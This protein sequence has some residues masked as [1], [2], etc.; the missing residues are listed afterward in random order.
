M[1][2]IK[3]FN[4]F[5]NEKFLQTHDEYAGQHSAPTKGDNAPMNDLTDIY[6]DD[7]YGND[8]LRMYGWNEDRSVDMESLHIIQ[9]AK[10]KPNKAVKIY[11]AIPDFNKEINAEIKV[12]SDILSYHDRFNFF[13][14]KNKEIRYT[15][16]PKYQEMFDKEEISYG[17][18]QKAIY[19]DISNDI[20][21]LAA[22]KLD[23]PKINKGDWVTIS[24]GYAKQHG[25]DNLKN[26]YKIISKTVRAKDLFTDGNDINEWGYDPQ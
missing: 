4:Q 25:R 10:G 21:K 3:K 9:S 7:I 26:K 8:A 2:N 5:L 16:E 14:P 18:M 11:R 22:K 12:L 6:P 1:A 13:P 20:D 17:D 24:K 15:Y 23:S 19:N